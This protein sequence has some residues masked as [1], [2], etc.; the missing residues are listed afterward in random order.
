MRSSVATSCT[1]TAV[2]PCRLT[3]ALLE[4][5]L[6]TTDRRVDLVREGFD[7]VLRIGPLADSTLVAQRLGTLRMLNC[8]SP[9]YLRRH[10]TPRTLDDLDGHLVV[11]YS[12]AL[13]ADP[14]T[15][16]FP[17]GGAYRQ[18]PMRCLVTVNSADA[19]EAACAAGL[20]IIQAPRYGLAAA[21]ARGDLV[22]IL[23]DHT[24]DPMPVQLVHAHGRNVPRRTRVVLTWIAQVLAPHLKGA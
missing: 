1:N 3:K 9:A 4:V 21:I 17:D 2:S 24:C 16:E 7:C 8:A 14:P 10:G 18:R 11:H 12:Q 23:P 5:Q 15:F 20:G 19:Y 13:G 22:E 6:S